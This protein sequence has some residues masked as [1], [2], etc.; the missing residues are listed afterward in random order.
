MKKTEEAF[1]LL[2]LVGDFP[3]DD[4]FTPRRVIELEQSPKEGQQLQQKVMS[5]DKNL[6]MLKARLSPS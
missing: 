1:H 5:I 2:H 4:A 6:L 3:I